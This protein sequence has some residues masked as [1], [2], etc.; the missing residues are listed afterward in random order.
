MRKSS[1]IVGVLSVAGVLLFA[2]AGFAGNVTSYCSYGSGN[3]ENGAWMSAQSTQSG[4]M[5]DTCPWYK[6][7]FG[8]HNDNCRWDNSNNNSNNNNSGC[9][10]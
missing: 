6:R 3:S 1:K 10:R 8:L 5:N 4:S 9:C 7:W 2:T